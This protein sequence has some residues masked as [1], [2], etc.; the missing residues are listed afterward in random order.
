MC[1]EDK[2]K[3]RTKQNYKQDVQEADISKSRVKERCAFNK[4][5]GFHFTENVTVDIMH[6]VLEGVAIY[7][8]SSI[9]Y[10]FVFEKK[11]YFTVSNYNN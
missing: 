8:M 6:D 11:I 1:A 10:T 9:I 2:S 4:V 5:N 7:I 3:L